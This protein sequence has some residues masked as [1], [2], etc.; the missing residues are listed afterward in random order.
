MR[1]PPSRRTALVVLALLAGVLA[2]YGAT[3]DH[4]F[5]NLDDPVYVSHNIHVNRGLT[6]GGLRWA[7]TSFHSA[8]WH[9]LTWISH[10]LDCSLWGLDPGPHHLTSLALH[11]LNTLL[12]LLALRKLSGDFWCSAFVAALFAVHPLHVESVAWIAER[13]DLLSGSFAMLTLWAYAAYVHRPTR[14]RYALTTA[15]FAAG[16]AS[17]PML[18]TLPLVLLLLDYWPL[19]R[20]RLAEKIPWFGLSA[21]SSVVTFLAQ[22]AGG[23]VVEEIPLAARMANAAVA[24]VLYLKKTVW[25]QDL[26]VFYPHP[27]LPGSAPFAAWQVA[28]A[29]VLLAA[30]SAAVIVLRRRPYLAVGWLWFC[31]MLVPVIGL[32]QIGDQA[33]ADRYTYLPLLGVFVALA[34]GAQDLARARPRL[35]APLA[36]TAGGLLLALSAVA[37]VQ[38]SHWRDSTTLF[39]HA[40]ATTQGNYVAHLNLGVVLE[41]RGQVDLALRHYRAA[42]DSRP[43]YANALASLGGLLAR[44]GQMEQAAAYL[45]RGVRADPDHPTVLY[46]L[47]WIEEQRGAPN[48]AAEYYERALAADPDN[49]DARINLGVLRAMAG[50]LP[51]A[52]AHFRSVLERYPADTD[53]LLN[54]GRVAEEHAALGRLTEARTIAE[55]ALARATAAGRADVAQAMRQR[56]QPLLR[57]PAP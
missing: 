18:V 44:I 17:K 30:V 20:P 2:V 13:K 11:A 39:E 46:N 42:V 56:L 8:N 16:L 10:M 49:V 34:W 21:A 43:D 35:R 29:A 4:Q 51:A 5:V 26:A 6:W 23:A 28:G 27:Y 3:R 54:L 41:E 48:R 38:V 31:G 9:P 45:E 14:G 36:A 15:L 53:A 32:A 22:R 55:E 7:L 40:L 37:R 25:P 33:L 57:T 24:Y 47:G 52:A 1:P 50:D 12:L 19:G